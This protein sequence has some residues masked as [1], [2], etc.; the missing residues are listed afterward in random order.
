VLREEY[1]GAV[2]QL[3]EAVSKWRYIGADPKERLTEHL[4]VLY[5]RGKL[6]LTDT[7]LECLFERAPDNLRGHALSFIG[8]ELFN[9]KEEI[10]TST[11]ERLKILWE[12]RTN[13]A[14]SSS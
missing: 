6:N 1:A 12:R 4:M 10:P 5:W 9:S 8:R 13:A 3:G 7:I 2:E 11:L 14:Q